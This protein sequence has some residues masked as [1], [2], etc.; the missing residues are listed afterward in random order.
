MADRYSPS[1]ARL[2]RQIPLGE[3]GDN[4]IHSPNPGIHREKNAFRNPAFI[5]V[6]FGTAHGKNV[7]NKLTPHNY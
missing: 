4:E 6:L 1:V 5:A 2:D 7:E 3:N